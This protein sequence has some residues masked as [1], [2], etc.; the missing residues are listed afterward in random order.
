MILLDTTVLVYAVGADHPLQP[1][2]RRV[3]E[4]LA[5]GQIRATTTPQ[6]I[7]EFTHVRARRRSRTDAVNLALS[8][9]KGLGPLA[10]MERGELEDGLALFQGSEV[11]GA[12]DAVLAA[13]AQHRGW[14]L[15]SA[16][17]AFGSVAGIT[18][19]DPASP[20]FLDDVLSR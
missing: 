4:L 19:L 2:C 20:S 13:I 16:D 10:Q 1:P 7:Q 8:Y 17:Q 5:L 15:A 11:L 3:I 12:F 18:V 6:V 14:V 9:A